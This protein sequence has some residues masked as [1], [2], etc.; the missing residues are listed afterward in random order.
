MHLILN[1]KIN[2]DSNARF[3]QSAREKAVEYFLHIH[4][5]FTKQIWQKM[6]FNAL[7]ILRFSIS[8]DAPIFQINGISYLPNS[9]F[10]LYS[11]IK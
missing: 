7:F 6:S 2:R 1:L 9:Y 5:F 11:P 10:T 8:C 4:Q 3:W